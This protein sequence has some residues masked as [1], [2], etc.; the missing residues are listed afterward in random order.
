MTAE[1]QREVAIANIKKYTGN[2]PSSASFKDG[3][4]IFEHRPCK[5]HERKISR[6]R[7]IVGMVIIILSRWLNDLVVLLLFYQTNEE[8][9]RSRPRKVHLSSES[10]IS[11]GKVLISIKHNSRF[12]KIVLFFC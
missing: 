6:N 1:V 11:I 9:S 10:L 8:E 4:K 2:I 5:R 3:R 7:F 12:R